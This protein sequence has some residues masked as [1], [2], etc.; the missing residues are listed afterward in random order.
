MSFLRSGGDIEDHIAI[1]TSRSNVE[2]TLKRL[3]FGISFYEERRFLKQ[4]RY[5]YPPYQDHA[6]HGL[7]ADHGRAHPRVGWTW[8]PAPIAKAEART[9]LYNVK[10]QEVVS[11][12]MEQVDIDQ[13][14]Q[15]G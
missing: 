4:E 10:R 5:D 8:R 13:T 3:D 9:R 6:G 1:L 2:K 14:G 7:V 11:E 15:G 12:F